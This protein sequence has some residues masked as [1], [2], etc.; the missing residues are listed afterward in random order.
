MI[1]LTVTLSFWKARD[2]VCNKVFF[3]VQKSYHF[4]MNSLEDGNFLVVAKPILVQRKFTTPTPLLI[5]EDDLKIYEEKLEEE[6]SREE[7]AKP[8]VCTI[9]N[10]SYS[11]KDSLNKHDKKV[12]EMKRFKC[13]LCDKIYREKV[14]LSFHKRDVH[15]I[16]SIKCSNCGIKVKTKR[17]LKIH[18]AVEHYV[19]HISLLKTNKNKKVQ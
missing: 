10:L 15:N 8:F 11:R 16:F 4:K 12:H 9:C 7:K 18:M 3:N 2:K 14:N 13:D 6:K 17:L 1:K 19:V 5:A